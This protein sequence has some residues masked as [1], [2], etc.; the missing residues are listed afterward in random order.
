VQS[1]AQQRK[2]EIDAGLRLCENYDFGLY[3]IDLLLH[4]AETLLEERHAWDACR[5]GELALVGGGEKSEAEM[6]LLGASDPACDYFWGQIG[7]HRVIGL[8]CLWQAAD[9]LQSA[10]YD[11]D[12]LAEVDS[13]THALV[14]RGRE[15]LMQARALASGKDPCL[16]RELEAV[17]GGLGRGVLA[18][19][20]QPDMLAGGS[21]AFDPEQTEA[22]ILLVGPRAEWVQPQ[23][24]RRASLL[25]RKAAR[26][27]LK[28]LLDAHRRAP[29]TALSRE[30]LAE[31]GW[32][33]ET[34][35]PSVSKRRFHTALWTL[36]RRFQLNETIVSRHDG[37]LLHPDLEVRY[38]SDD[39]D[40][41]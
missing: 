5:D 40:T 33:G 36:R 28:A 20:W 35:S 18:D 34:L 23:G 9:R 11:P 24:G 1:S 3:R 27:I 32:P 12:Q 4:R 21:G 19:D 7:A 8:A 10:E 41:T 2:E 17:L 39:D 13:S 30:R 22:P 14:V 29:G 38:A 31:V 6:K 37:Y 25:T 26:S 16:T 15:H